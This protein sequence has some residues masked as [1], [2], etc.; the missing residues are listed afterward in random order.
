M[1]YR[2]LFLLGKECRMYNYLLSI[3]RIK[4]C[5]ELMN[6]ENYMSELVDLLKVTKDYLNL[7]LRNLLPTGLLSPE[8]G[9]ER[10]MERLHLE[11]MN[12]HN[13]GDQRS[14]LEIGCIGRAISGN[15]CPMELLQSPVVLMI[16]SK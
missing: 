1:D 2:M 10:S 14:R 12:V 5:V 11:T 6:K 9:I 16:K 4:G 15:I 13:R 7:M 3:E 8:N